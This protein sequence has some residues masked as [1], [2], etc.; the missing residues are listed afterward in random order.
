MITDIRR[1]ARSLL[2]SPYVTIVAVLSIGLGV[3]AATAVYSWMD[4]LVLHP[5]PAVREQDAIVGIEVGEPNGGMGAWS[6]RT[7]NE[8][9]QGLRS[10]SGMAA[11]N[12]IRVS[13]RLPSEEVSTS[14]LA[15]DVSPTY[16]DVLGVRPVLG[17]AITAA[18][19]ETRAPVALLGDR[20]WRERFQGDPGVIGR[21]LLLNGVAVQVVGVLPPGFS[22]VYT[23]VVPQ[24]DVPI[25]LQ[26]TLTGVD[27]LTDRKIRRW[28]VFARLGP[29][30][31][32]EAA[33]RETDGLAKRIS[34]GYGDRPA[35]GATVMFLR[36]QFLGATLSPFFSA[37]LAVTGL[38]LALAAANVASLLVVRADARRHETAVRVAL[39]ASRARVFQ[40]VLAESALLAIAGSALGVAIAYLGRGA[41]YSFVPR[42]PFPLSLTVPVDLRVLAAALGAATLVTLACGLAPARASMRV[43]PQGALAA[44]ARSLARAGTRL[45]TAIVTGQLALCV[46]FLVL[47]GMFVRGLQRA[48]AIDRGFSDPEHVLLVSTNLS[49]GRF[50]DSTGEAALTQLLTRL[51]AL[52]GVRAASVATMVPLGFGGVDV[53]EMKAEGYA[54]AQGEDMTVNRS[55]IGTDYAATMRIRV[56]EG[57]DLLAADRAGAPLVAIVNETLARRFFPGGTA[58]GRRFDAGRGWATIVGVYRDGKYE[59]LDERPVPMA[60]LPVAQWYQPSLTLHVRTAEE[61]TLLT[62]P[63]R[64]TLQSVH[65][66]LPALQPRTLSEHVSAATFVPR[67]G[68]A[69]LGAMAA[70]ALAL[71]VVGLYGALA[72][73][74]TM[75]Q[76]E[77]AV[78]MALG[79]T[80]GAV[81]WVV[82]RS[83]MAIT[84]AGLAI[85]AMLALAAG[86]LVRTELTS[87]APS[88]PL[89]YLAA[90]AVL[91]AAAAIATWVPARRAVRLAPAQ[92]L[93]DG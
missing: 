35:P 74:V 37:L 30:V 41:L 50:S 67:I 59:T 9:A 78:R 26:P 57:R 1:A 21:T 68:S 6:Y 88:E 23:G 89:V 55:F 49:A 92:L 29:G 25:T 77:I 7:F 73:A 65:A 47:A 48:T 66:D 52:P 58:I 93:R 76:K 24:F 83:A 51:R 70:A 79:A 44:G 40:G 5:F 90:F 11:W 63:I 8:L 62:E 56:V 82:A 10:Y 87:V 17:R 31:T 81:M 72:V 69:L 2:R 34:A 39:G 42:G 43:A 60:Y 61:P 19:V 3:G 12:I 14:L 85:G 18:D 64:R 84:A 32:R 36:V 75:R 46:V 91:A 86:A 28:L 33:L 16:F 53:F 15:T 13:V 22:G 4:G 80:R 45:R 71:C 54:P 27:L 38:L 20:Y